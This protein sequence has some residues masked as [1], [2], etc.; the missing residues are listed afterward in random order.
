METPPIP[1]ALKRIWLTASLLFLTIYGIAQQHTVTAYAP[2]NAYAGETITI[3]GT[4]LIGVTGISFGGTPVTSYN[5]VSATSITAVVGAGSTGS[6][7]VSKTGYTDVTVTGFTYSTYPTVSRI[8]TDFG[9]FWNTNT[10]LNNGTY[11]NDAHHLLAFTYS[12]VT[13]STGVNDASLINNGVTFTSG[14]Y[15]SLP[16]VLNGTT[17]GGS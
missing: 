8:I 17:F 7:V 9:G 13:Y 14:N 1:S 15:K 2:K 4:N 3:S 12:G 6:M 10:T 11:P 5:I 16:A